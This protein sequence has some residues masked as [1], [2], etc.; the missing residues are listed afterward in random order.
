MTGRLSSTCLVR[1]IWPDFKIDRSSLLG[2]LY[3]LPSE[4]LRSSDGQTRW[5]AYPILLGVPWDS[6]PHFSPDGQK[7]V[8]RSDAGLGVENIWTMPWRGCR[9]AALRS[10]DTD[11][12][13]AHPLNESLLQAL[14]HEEEDESWMAQGFKEDGDKRLRRLLREGRAEAHRVTNETY[15]WVSDA[16]FHP[17]GDK[18]CVPLVRTAVQPTELR[19]FFRSSQRSGT[20]P[21]GH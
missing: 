10:Y 7:L 11:A 21:E 16:R 6:D 14:A 15:R 13:T 18:V 12:Q 19:R 4:A 2:D 20:R 1:R 17:D 3:C 8:F 5:R 9:T